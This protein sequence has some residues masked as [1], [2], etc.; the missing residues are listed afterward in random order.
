MKFK[1]RVEQFLNNEQLILDIRSGL[2]LFVS[3]LLPLVYFLYSKN[4]SISGLLA[5]EFGVLSL[6]VIFG[7][8][9]TFLEISDK[10]IRDEKDNNDQI[11]E[12]EKKTIDKQNTL[13]KKIDSV[14]EFNRFYNEQEQDNKNKELTNERIA[15]LNNKITNC[16]IKQKP[17]SQY[18]EEI[19]FLEHNPLY[20]KS[21]KPVQLRYIIAQ[22]TT[23]KREIKGNDAIHINPRTYGMRKFLMKQPIKALSI[24][25]SGMFILG[26]S[27]DIG[28]ILMFYLIYIIS[29]AVLVSFRYPFVRKVTRTLYSTTLRNKQDYITEYHDWIEAQEEEYIYTNSVGIPDNPAKIAQIYYT[30]QIEKDKIK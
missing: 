2:I 28:T 29:L 8:V 20:D 26:L 21:Y 17:Y 15:Y 12:E 14:I 13:P 24:G 7:N 23:A 27:D 22:N 5:F 10:A 19:A 6:I 18:E 30:E 25:G 4:F 11:I 1:D 3:I 9:L 16:K